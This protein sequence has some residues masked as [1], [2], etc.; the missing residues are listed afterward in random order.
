MRTT[1]KILIS[2]AATI[3]LVTTMFVLFTTQSVIAQENAAAEKLAIEAFE[4]FM[5]I[6]FVEK[7]G[8]DFM[9]NWERAQIVHDTLLASW[10]KNGTFK[11]RSDVQK[12][13]LYPDFVGGIYYNDEGNFV[14]QIVNDATAKIAAQSSLNLLSA[15][16][17]SEEQETVVE[18][19]EY[20]YNEL[21]EKIESIDAL[22]M[23]D[24]KPEAFENVWSY[25]VDTIDNRIE[26]NLIDRSEEAIAQLKG[27]ALDSP[28]VAI[29]EIAKKP[30]IDYADIHP[31]MGM[32]NGSYSV[33]YRAKSSGCDSKVGFVTA[34]H[35]VSDGQ[36]IKI[37]STEI[38]K[39]TKWQKSGN[40]DA[41]FVQ[42]NSSATLSNNLRSGPPY[43]L[44]P[45][46]FQI[47]F[48]AGNVVMK[49]GDRTVWTSGVVTN[50]N[51]TVVAGGVLFNGLVNTNM[52]GNQ[53][54]S[55]GIVF[56]SSVPD[57]RLASTLGIVKAGPV[58][59]GA[60]CFTRA[61]RINDAFDL[62]RY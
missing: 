33:G 60:M 1:P 35:A 44:D 15:S 8:K 3:L 11:L 27:T 18:Y 37:G 56:A 21:N 13:A 52:Y 16:K 25:G 58:G 30:Y 47:Y 36:T 41:A 43:E 26:Y 31:G 32:A 17:E 46:L 34:A 24:E 39:V 5:E 61:D 20:S 14:L 49:I 29:N 40:V 48:T 6:D 9:R 28:I 59:G 38:G 12:E 53:G 10:S 62:E 2:L 51:Y 55:G 7:H 42:T 23:S 22:F 45:G 50:A 54:D 57:Y 19:V 4:N